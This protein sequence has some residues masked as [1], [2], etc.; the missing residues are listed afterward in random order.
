MIRSPHHPLVFPALAVL[1]AALLSA[2]S[3]TL[4][5]RDARFEDAPLTALLPCKP[6]R[7]S[8]P[9]V[10]AGQPVTLAMMGCEAGGAMFAVA[11]AEAGDAGRVGDLLANWQAATLANIRAAPVGVAAG[12]AVAEGTAGDAPI[13]GATT[14]TPLK[15]P[16]A[17]TVPTPSRVTA[18]GQS[19]DGKPVMSEAAY[20]AK[21]SQVFQAVVYAEKM[22]PDASEAFFSGLRLQ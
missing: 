3:P 17:S 14:A 15:I 12:A 20:F 13:P 7:A 22:N 19:A 1:A 11:M 9:V 6:D 2:C 4:N 8:K 16:G 21:G 5:W 18:R 10:M